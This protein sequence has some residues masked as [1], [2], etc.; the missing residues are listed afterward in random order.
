MKKIDSIPLISD[1]NISY[2]DDYKEWWISTKDNILIS[3]KIAIFTNQIFISKWIELKN[4]WVNYTKNKFS[5]IE[6]KDITS[7]C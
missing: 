3:N 4:K 7:F 6:S 2:F 5:N 1:I